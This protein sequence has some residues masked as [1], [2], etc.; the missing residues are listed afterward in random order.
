[1]RKHEIA[2]IIYEGGQVDVFN[3]DMN[4]APMQ[5][6]L[7][8]NTIYYTQIDY[9]RA[10]QLRNVGI[11]LFAGGVGAGVLGYILMVTGAWNLNVGTM[12]VGAVLFYVSIPVTVAGIVM[13]PIGQT[14]MN[15][16]NRLSPNGF[17]LFENEK[18][19]LNLAGNG[20]R[21]NF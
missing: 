16:I 5:Q 7:P 1:M 19:Q 20:L 17:S 10:K 3:L 4:T 6:V 12:A 9:E 14:R 11:G 15:R 2:T 18:V 8:N 13:W 21:L